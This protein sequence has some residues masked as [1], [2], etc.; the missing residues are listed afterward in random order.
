MARGGRLGSA[1][2]A[3]PPSSAVPPAAP[4]TDRHPPPA[5]SPQEKPLPRSP[6]TLSDV[7]AQPC[8]NE[9]R[10]RHTLALTNS[11]AEIDVASLRDQ[12]GGAGVD[13]DLVELAYRDC[14]T[15][16]SPATRSVA[17]LRTI[18]QCRLTSVRP[19]VGWDRIQWAC[20]DR[21]AGARRGVGPAPT[22]LSDRTSRAAVGSI[23]QAD[24]QVSGD[25]HY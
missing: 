21:G 2:G 5:L 25:R 17:R 14:A 10:R 15:A 7:H 13:P 20:A 22:E 6:R 4:R 16:S 8:Q 1:A 12:A 11:A 18:R 3:Q 23:I 19:G 9:T 24:S